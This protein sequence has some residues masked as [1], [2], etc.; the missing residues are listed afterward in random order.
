MNKEYL[1]GVDLYN[2]GYLWES[3]EAWEGLWRA[4]GRYSVEGRFLQSLI[5]NSAALLKMHAGCWKGAE[6]HSRRAV[7]QLNAVCDRLSGDPV[8]MGLDAP[9]WKARLTAY[10]APLW[11]GSV[12]DGAAGL[13][14]SPPCL[15]LHDNA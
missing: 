15:R 11:N 1:F 6:T 7:R 4:A 5:F 8:F 2:Q 12:T 10:Y 14:G 13:P 9:L 3:H